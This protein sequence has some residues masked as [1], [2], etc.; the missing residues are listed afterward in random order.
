MLKI[1]YKDILEVGWFD[2]INRNKHHL[3][4]IGHLTG[5]G[6]VDFGNNGMEINKA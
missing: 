5:S 3:T 1:N 2:S 4:E 6:L